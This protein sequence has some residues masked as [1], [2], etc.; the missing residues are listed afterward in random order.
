MAA[1][2]AWCEAPKQVGPICPQCGADYAKAEAIKSTGKAESTQ[3]PEATHAE[4]TTT[5]SAEFTI[6]VKD[7]EF[8]KAVCLLALP[9]MLCIALFVQITGF[10]SG[11]QRIFFAMPVH[12]LG[13]AVTGWLCGFNSIPTLWKTLT[14]ENRGYFSSFLLL[15]GLGALTRYGLKNKQALWLFLTA[16]ILLLQLYGTFVITPGKADMYITM[17]GDAMGMILATL[18][19]TSFYVGKDTQIYKGALRWGFLGIGAAAFIN[20]FAPWWNKDITAIGYGLTGGIPTDSWKMIN[21]HLWQW[22]ALFNVHITLGLVC[23]TALTIS[24][25][26]GLKQANHWIKEQERL[27]RLER[28]KTV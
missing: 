7:P 8:E 20:I 27:V 15:I 26:L 10:L 17:G 4:S 6:P 12:E 28:L 24:Y 23:L 3:F 11:M 5:D 22:D 9:S 18:L 2:C 13:H 19:M 16:I 25:L 21:I 14:P 1:T